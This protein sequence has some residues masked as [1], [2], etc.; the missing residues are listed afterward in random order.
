[1]ST[2]NVTNLPTQ[3]PR[4]ATAWVNF[5]GT[6]TVAIRDQFNVS[7][8]TDNGV[9]DYTVNFTTSLADANYTVSCDVNQVNVDFSGGTVSDQVVRTTAGYT[10]KAWQWS[11]SSAANSAFYDPSI[12]SVTIFGGNV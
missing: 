1:M 9:G 5:N 12:A 6:G 10:F 11:Q 4:M 8:I 3:E 2:L 7:S